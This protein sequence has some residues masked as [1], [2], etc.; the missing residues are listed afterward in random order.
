M[1]VIRIA[2]AQ[3]NTTVGDLDG[4]ADLVRRS[5][6]RARSVGA[7]LALFPELTIPGYP[8]ED[9]LLRPSFQRDCHAVVEDL[10]AES[11]G[12]SVVIGTVER[13]P[14]GLRNAAVLYHDGLRVSTYFKQRLPNYGVFDEER[15]F[16]PGERLTAVDL[17]DVRIG[18]TI[19][20]DLWVPNGP[21]APLCR[22]G[23]AQVLLNLSAS[24]FHIG[25]PAAR[26]R[27]FQDLGRS[28]SCHVV[29]CNLIGGQDELIFDGSS[30]HI[31]PR[32]RAL[33]RGKQ[34]EEDML[35]L[36][37][38]TTGMTD[39]NDR[40]WRRPDRIDPLQLKPIQRRDSVRPWAGLPEPPCEPLLE[41]LDEVYS[42]L[43]LGTRDYVRK[44]GF[45]RVVVGLSGGID[46]ALTA[47]IASD[48][49]GPESVVGV[50]MPSEFTAPESTEDARELAEQ[51]G[52]EFIE[53]P[54]TGVY[55]RMLE[56]LKPVFDDSEFGVAE[57][58]LQARIRGN[59][60]MALANKFGWL[61]LTTGN[62]SEV[63]VGYCTLYGD[64]AGGFAVLKDLYK[65]AVYEQAR[66]R[67]L[68][69]MVIP[70]RIMSREP[71]AELRPDQ[72]DTDSLPRYE[73]LDLI[74]RASVEE[75]RSLEEIVE[76]GV[77][78]EL[79]IRILGLID[80]AEYKRRQSPPGIKIT[81]KAFGK[82]RRLPIT[83]AYT[84]GRG[85]TQ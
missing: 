1:S 67:N 79:A 40:R 54:I 8:P 85:Q 41:E 38:V 64:T 7:D 36:D 69:G 82:D 16:E 62:K 30:L 56:T 4:N 52:I 10:A 12:L 17:K 48:A 63:A 23:G 60:L 73:V 32:G 66:L 14:E 18:I 42:A 80:Q 34:F 5:I 20:E 44:N 37:L 76:L 55:E 81:R 24:P 47:V 39:A 77:D 3:I 68:R 2:L 31:D 19:C 53:L 84:I 11:K 25:K 26:E 58:N 74:L 28:L 9:L 57:E 83:S 27:I 33:A 50:A 51:L 70:E 61:V 29:V 71:S 65:T 15:Y 21:A 75:E 6:D 78:R 22:D 43:C 45:E 49:L 72:R 59:L 35:V 13:S 46:S